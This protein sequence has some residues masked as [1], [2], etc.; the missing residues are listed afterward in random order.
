MKEVGG[1]TV[2]RFDFS[3][4]NKLADLIYFEGPLLSLYEGKS[5]QKLLFLWADCD[6]SF[7]RWVVWQV[8][9]DQ[10][11][12]YVRR[13]L[14]LRD[15]LLHPTQGVVTI[16]DIDSNL[17]VADARILAPEQVPP[18]Y[19]PAVDSTFDD[20]L[21]ELVST[22]RFAIPINGHWEVEDFN[23][24]PKLLRQAYAFFCYFVLE[25]QLSQLPELPMRDGFSSMHFF[26]DLSQKLPSNMRLNLEAVQYASPG[27]IVFSG[28][29]DITER[30]LLLLD[31]L[32]YDD[33]DAKASYNLLHGILSDKKLLGVDAKATRVD[34]ALETEILK[35]TV[36]LLRDLKIPN[37]RLIVERSATPLSA[38]KIA[39][40]FF[41]LMQ[42]RLCA[43]LRDHR[44]SLPSTFYLQQLASG[45]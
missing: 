15:L 21:P 16:V 30:V 6:T 1:A 10:L 8:S 39:L 40:A 33:Q 14:S 26:K 37:E 38:A 24:F 34:E 32:T 41:R 28:R 11:H 5:G 13:R 42:D 23:L 27:A 12:E 18:D 25:G 17:V 36:A 9:D 7:N 4:L 35:M 3:Q 29:P 45:E 22:P 31:Q 2:R 20:P 44:A 43:Y 19:L